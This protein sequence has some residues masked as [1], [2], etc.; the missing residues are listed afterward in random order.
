MG[1][2]AIIVAKTAKYY[3]AGTCEF[4]FKDDKYYFLEMNTRL[5]VEHPITEITTGLDLVREQLKIASGFQIEYDQEDINPRGLAIECRINAEDPLNN[6]SPSP[7]KIIRYAEPSGPGIRVDSGVY[8]GFTIPPFYDS[9][10]AKLIISAEDRNRCIERTKRAL[11]EFQIGGV[12]NNLPFH[13]VVM[14][15][16]KWIKGDYD[17]SFIPK[18]KILEQVVNY[19]KEKKTQS[20]SPKTAAAMAAVQAYVLAS[21]K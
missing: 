4:M 15:N 8:Q 9:M 11:W 6:F 12:R 16:E 2:Q 10:I 3:N 17:T 18:Y 5:Q 19:V 14:N 1:N 7:S 20:S 21:K 13:E